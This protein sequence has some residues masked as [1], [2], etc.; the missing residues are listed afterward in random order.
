MKN[1]IPVC[2]IAFSAA[3]SGAAHAQDSFTLMNH[4]MDPTNV[5]ELSPFN[6]SADGY[7]AIYEN[8]GGVVSNFLGATRIHAGANGTT[9]VNI[10]MDHRDNVVALLFL[11][12]NYM[13]PS[14]AVDSF[15]IQ[16]LN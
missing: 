13:D 10:G 8:H 6:A 2:V 16:I 11:G 14:T 12:N 3:F 15:E 1:F 9:R 7:V 4:S 5:I